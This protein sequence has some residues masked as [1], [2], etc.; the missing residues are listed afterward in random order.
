MK[1]RAA[2]SASPQRDCLRLAACHTAP[3]LPHCATTSVDET[4]LR[5][6]ARIRSWFMTGRVDAFIAWLRAAVRDPL[7]RLISRLSAAG[8]T[9]LTGAF[10]RRGGLVCLALLTA[11]GYGLYAHPPF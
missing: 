10:R 1:N 5:A 4:P 7:R 9:L 6:P 8:R 2:L 11:A 3:Q